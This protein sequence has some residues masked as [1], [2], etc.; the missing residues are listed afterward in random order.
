MDIIYHPHH[1]TLHVL[2][3]IA[4]TR[5]V[6]LTLQNVHCEQPGSQCVCICSNIKLYITVVV[7]HL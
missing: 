7:S 2:T 3:L 6:Y 4:I 5:C 1:I